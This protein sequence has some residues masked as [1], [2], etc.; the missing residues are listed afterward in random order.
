MPSSPH[1][2]SLVAVHA[3]GI[4]LGEGGLEWVVGLDAIAG[5]ARHG[6]A[7]SQGRRHGR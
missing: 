2:I 7:L 5:R 4:H 6:A 3:R 1:Q